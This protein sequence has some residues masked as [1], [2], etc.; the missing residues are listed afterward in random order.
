MDRT[1]DVVLP[2]LDEAAALEWVLTRMPVGARPIVVDNGSTDGSA[3]V[4][5]AL[6]ATV[7]S[8]WRRG[9][10]AACHAGLEAATAPL[11]AVMDCDATLDPRELERFV[12]A[13]LAED[14]PTLAVG[15]RV[16]VSAASW[17]WPLRLANRV[18]VARVN[19]RT[20]LTLA[21]VGPMRAAPRAALLN[22][23]LQDRRSGY[24]VETVVRAAEAG[25]RVVQLDVPYASR[26]GRSKVT[27]TPL[28]AARAVRDMTAVLGR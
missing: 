27:G 21:D 14:V 17:P 8:E 18:V 15:R 23:G 4:A 19:R 16:P 2:C 26:R 12:D 10:G 5:A 24:P 20:G 22:L 28:G 7:V 9:Y 3:E 1:L 6:G 25:W 11:V 13:V